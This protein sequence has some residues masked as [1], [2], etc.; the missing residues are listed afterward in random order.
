MVK[1]FCNSLKLYIFLKRLIYYSNAVSFHII[2][3]YYSL[4]EK[5]GFAFV[6]WSEEGI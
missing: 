6:T 5:F 4:S 2:V 3:L 1:T